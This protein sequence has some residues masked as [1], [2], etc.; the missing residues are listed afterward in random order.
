VVEFREGVKRRVREYGGELAQCDPE[1][2][3]AP[4]AREE[5][6]VGVDGRVLLAG[7]RQLLEDAKVAGPEERIDASAMC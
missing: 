7:V 3:R 4:G 1:V 2:R 6:D 5:Q